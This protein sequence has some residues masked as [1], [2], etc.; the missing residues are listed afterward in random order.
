MVPE[1]TDINTDL[2][3]GRVTDPDMALSNSP[4][5]D[6]TMSPGGSRGHSDW[7]GPSSGMTLGNNVT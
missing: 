7:Q 2:G 4:D 1:A 3:W 6:N 5:P